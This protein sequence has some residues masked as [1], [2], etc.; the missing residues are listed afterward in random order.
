MRKHDLCPVIVDWLMA[1]EVMRRLGF[2]PDE[3]FFAVYPSGIVQEPDGTSKNLGGPI[4]ALEIR[5]GEQEFKWSIGVTS[6][7]PDVIQAEYE[8]ACAMWNADSI[9]ISHG[10]FISSRP[11]RMSIALIQELQA[12][13]FRLPQ[14][15]LRG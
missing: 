8:R 4:I 15:P 14:T 13:G 6:L 12:R 1:C 11:A 10:D 7:A 2:T 5:R 3:V 9:G